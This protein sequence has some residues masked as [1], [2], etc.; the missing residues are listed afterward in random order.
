MAVVCL[1]DGSS[2]SEEEIVAW[3]AEN[4]ATYKAPRIVK[5]IPWSEMPYGV[6]LKIMKK[7]LRTRFA[8]AVEGGSSSGEAS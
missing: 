8:P 2:L 1:K 4:I 5:I 3:C 7:D 6:T